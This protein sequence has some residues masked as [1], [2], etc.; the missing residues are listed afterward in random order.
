MP[1]ASPRERQILQEDLADPLRRLRRTA[2]DPTCGK[3]AERAGLSRNTV[4]NVFNARRLARSDTIEAIVV[5][6]NG[7]VTWWRHQWAATRDR[8]DQLDTEAAETPDPVPAEPVAVEPAM[9]APAVE[10]P[11]R[12]TPARRRRVRRLATT[13]AAALAL[14]VTGGVVW[15]TTMGDGVSGASPAHD[16]ESRTH[17][18]PLPHNLP[19]VQCADRPRSI[20]TGPG[21][22]RGGR[23]L[24][25]LAP[26]ERFIVTSQTAFW[27]YGHTEA[28]PART[29]WVL[30]DYL[31]HAH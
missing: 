21:R 2:G 24:G 29:G 6:L 4:D 7:D 16:E 8:I 3:I 20:L 30:A 28:A 5:A 31:C 25:E 12:E 11:S 19:Y 22:S 17:V 27:K 26:G 13:I 18:Q 10:T 9:R 15:A 14:I 1:G 23:P